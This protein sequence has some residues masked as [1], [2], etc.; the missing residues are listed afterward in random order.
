[1]VTGAEEFYSPPTEMINLEANRPLHGHFHIIHHKTGFKADFYPLGQ[2]ELH[3]WGMAHRKKIEIE[4]EP[5]WVAAPEYVILR[6]LQYYREGR[7]ERHLQDIASI[8]EF[9]YNQIDSSSFRTESTVTPSKRN[10]TR[11]K[12]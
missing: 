5:F 4:G 6:K 7:S 2:D 8:L 1:M 3:E 10:G 11:Q 12:R 9:S